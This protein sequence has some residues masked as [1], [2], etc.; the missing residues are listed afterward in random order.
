MGEPRVGIIGGSG[1]YE[2]EGLTDVRWHRVRTPF[3]DPSDAYCIG[4]LGDREI[5][6]LPR[7]GRGHRLIPSELPFRA[8]LY[9]MK[10][11]GVEWVISVSA[12][13]SMRE[14]IAPLDL[15]IPD[16]FYDHT[17]RRIPSFFEEGIVAH[18]SM[19][20]PVCPDLAGALQAAVRRD[21]RDRSTGAA[22]TSASR[23]RSSRRR[24]SPGSTGAGAST[25]SG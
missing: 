4:R 15:V 24:P 8:N 20:E 14:R 13:G 16:Q 10:A 23:A 9:G 11:L 19:A 18:V 25:S 22:R 12:V 5:V 1:L 2:L 3:G 21:R 6:F 17:K 7:H